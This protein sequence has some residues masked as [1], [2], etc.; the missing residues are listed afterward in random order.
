M[1]GVVAIRERLLALLACEALLVVGAAEGVRHL[2]QNLLLANHAGRASGHERAA[3]GH[4][5]RHYNLARLSRRLLSGERGSGPRRDDATGGAGP[6][7]HT[8]ASSPGATGHAA[9]TSA[10]AAGD[11]ASRPGAAGHAATSTNTST[12]S[13]GNA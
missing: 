4:L 12:A 9:T 11:A 5:V 8:A 1:L 6:A 2:A 13:A 7:G 10:G 3:I